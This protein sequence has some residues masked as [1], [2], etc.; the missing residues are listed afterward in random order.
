MSYVAGTAS[1]FQGH[2]AWDLGLQGAAFLSYCFRESNGPCLFNPSPLWQP[3]LHR[4]HLWFRWMSLE[5]PEVCSHNS[6]F[7]NSHLKCPWNSR[8]AQGMEGVLLRNHSRKE[9][10][11]LA[12]T[13]EDTAASSSWRYFSLYLAA[14]SYSMKRGVKFSPSSWWKC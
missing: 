4:A 6:T 2:G 12:Q 11:A 7:A 13:L 1:C 10:A 5:F 8:R 14:F 9:E 3:W